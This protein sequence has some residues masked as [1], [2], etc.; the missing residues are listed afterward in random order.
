[1]DQ[2]PKIRIVVADDHG[3]VRAGLS[4][5]INAEPDM[6]VVDEASDGDQAIKLVRELQPDLL[7]LDISMPFCNG[8]TV[9]H[10]ITSEM[11]SVKVL[12]LTMHEDR[13]YVEK[14]L[15]AGAAGYI[16]KRAADNDLI[17]AIRTVKEGGVFIHPAAAKLLVDGMRGGFKA[18]ENLAGVAKISKATDDLS[19]RELEVLRLIALGHSNQ[20]IAESLALSVKTVE[21][22]KANINRK[23]NLNSRAE[24]VRYALRQ[25]LIPR[26]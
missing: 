11:P 18:K 12:I 21:S 19:P 4:H 16:V 26:E 2:V 22:H 9:V 6:M 24:L 13:E 7:L 23:L 25:G 15:A 3:V 20:E 14:A 8:F 17:N 10:R 1:M 5:I